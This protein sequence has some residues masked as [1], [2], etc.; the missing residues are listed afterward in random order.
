MMLTDIEEGKIY[1][2]RPGT[3]LYHQCNGCACSHVRI[4]KLTYVGESDAD[5]FSCSWW[6]HM[7]RRK[8]FMVPDREFDTDWWSRGYLEEQLEASPAKLTDEMVAGMIEV[9]LKKFGIQAGVTKVV[10]GATELSD[11]RYLIW[12]NSD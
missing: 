3:K 7:I 5:V 8:G 2:A 9:E 12:I 6:S 4:G 1:T 11:G 10:E